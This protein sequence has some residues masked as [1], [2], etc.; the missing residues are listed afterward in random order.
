MK[1]LGLNHGKHGLSN[2]SDEVRNVCISNDKSVNIEAYQIG[3]NMGW[4]DFCTPFHGF[5]LGE[6]GD[7]YKS[8]CPA[9][10]ENLFREKYLIGKKVYEKKDQIHK[11]Y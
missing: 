4:S 3:F 10:K 7:I 2:Y 1:T 5:E 11:A 6:K 9:E 8:S